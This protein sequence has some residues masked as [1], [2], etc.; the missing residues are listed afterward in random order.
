MTEP[1]DPHLAQRESETGNIQSLLSNFGAFLQIAMFEP[2]EKWMDKCID[3]GLP[4][5]VEG[6][7]NALNFSKEVSN[8]NI[9]PYYISI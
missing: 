6:L 4:T 9:P 5:A 7:L 2:T 1:E 3:E 8:S